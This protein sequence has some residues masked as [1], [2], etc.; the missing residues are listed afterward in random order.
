MQGPQK[1]CGFYVISGAKLTQIA[2]EPIHNSIEGSK[3]LEVLGSEPGPLL[4]CLQPLASSSYT[5]S[6]SL[7]SI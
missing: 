4:S 7:E 3:P 1:R 2:F 5:L 6:E